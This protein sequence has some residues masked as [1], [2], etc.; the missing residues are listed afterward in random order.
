MAVQEARDAPTA[1][2]ADGLELL[3]RRVHRVEAARVQLERAD[4]PDAGDEEQEAP[5]EV[6]LP[7]LVLGAGFGVADAAVGVACHRLAPA[8]D[9]DD[10]LAGVV[11]GHRC[12]GLAM[13]HPPI[14]GVFRPVAL[15]VRA[16]GRQFV[17]HHH[18]PVVRRKH[19][20]KAIEP[21]AVA[22]VFAE[23][24]KDLLR[25][26]RVREVL[27]AHGEPGHVLRH[28]R[29][30]QARQ[31]RGQR[32]LDLVERLARRNAL[33]VDG[34]CLRVLGGGTAERLGAGADLPAGRNARWALPKHG[35]WHGIAAPMVD[36]GL[37]HLC[38]PHGWRICRFHA[39]AQA[40]PVNPVSWLHTPFQR[41]APRRAV[42]PLRR[43][44]QQG[45]CIWTGGHFS[46]P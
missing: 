37:R 33:L 25:D 13:A 14:G 38:A 28:Q 2:E 44:P 22:T 26:L 27:P 42:R 17:R 4:R 12:I 24:M 7:L 36:D 9:A 16:P 18:L 23:G 1:Q 3:D 6:A 29:R 32:L 5:A 21:M 30:L 19:H 35:G 11:E 10:A 8:E 40:G 34:T 15:F 39:L 41:T 43:H 31:G 45:A 20:R 46:D